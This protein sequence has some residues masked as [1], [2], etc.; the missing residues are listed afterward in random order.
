MKFHVVNRKLIFSLL[1]YCN[2]TRSRPS[3]MEK[4]G[5][6]S[7]P[8][9]LQFSPPLPL[10]LHSQFPRAGFLSLEQPSQSPTLVKMQRLVSWSGP[11][12]RFSVSSNFL[13]KAD[14]A[15]S[16]QVTP[17]A[18]HLFGTRSHLHPPIFTGHPTNSRRSSGTQQ[19]P[20]GGNHVSASSY[21]IHYRHHFILF[22]ISPSLGHAPLPVIPPC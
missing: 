13:E 6:S 3:F 5:P 15:T 16:P 9:S 4:S 20:R 19:S 22:E 7:S 11:R 1:G 8:Q 17:Q 12:L 18:T 14:T 10:Q 21:L 2:G